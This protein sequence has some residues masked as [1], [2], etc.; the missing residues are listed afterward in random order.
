MAEL[1]VMFDGETFKTRMKR[2]DAVIVSACIHRQCNTKCACDWWCSSHSWR[3]R[4]IEIVHGDLFGERS[5]RVRRGQ[6]GLTVVHFEQVFYADCRGHDLQ[7]L[8]LLDR[9]RQLPHVN[10]HTVHRDPKLL[11]GHETD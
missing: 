4:S 5:H 7:N 11:K 1:K 6:D 8:R 9:P 2:H 10:L 3:V